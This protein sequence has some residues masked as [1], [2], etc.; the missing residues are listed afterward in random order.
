MKSAI[1][2]FWNWLLNPPLEGLP[3]TLLVRLMAGGVFLSEGIQKFIFP[4]QG[5]M[6]FKLLGFPWP[7]ATASF[8]GTLE[9]VGG[10]L[11]IA[12]LLTRFT[13]ILFVFQMVVAILSTKISL[14][15]GTYPLPLP[16][17]PPKIGFWAVM[18]EGRSDAAQLL[19]CLYLMVA[20]PGRWSLDALSRRA[21]LHAGGPGTDVPGPPRPHPAL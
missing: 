8:I 13:T 1:A 5:F 18:H 19:T 4:S 14:F 9:I 11:L 7:A 3:V 21:V 6:R 16:P 20:G 15:R 2:R 10:A 17:V 12:G